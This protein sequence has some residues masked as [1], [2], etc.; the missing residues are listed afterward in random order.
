MIKLKKLYMKDKVKKAFTPG[1]V[2][3][4]W[5]TRKLSSFLVRTKLQSL[6]R[7]VGSFK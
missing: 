6:E 2:V 1:H 4:F 7:S 3:S 5:G